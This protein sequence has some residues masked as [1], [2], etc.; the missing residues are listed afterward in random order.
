MAGSH[1]IS[2]GVECPSFQTVV[3]REGEG[4]DLVLVMTYAETKLP[5]EI[6]GINQY[7]IDADVGTA[8]GER[9]F[10]SVDFFSSGYL[11]VSVLPVCL[12][13]LWIQ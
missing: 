11:D 13:Y 4:F 1:L 12:T 9:A 3:G 7:G 2:I 8:V 10:V 5:L 6:G